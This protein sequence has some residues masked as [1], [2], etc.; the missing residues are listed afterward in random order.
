MWRTRDGCHRSLLVHARFYHFLTFKG[1]KLSEIWPPIQTRTGREI[2]STF[3]TLK[4]KIVC[5][6]T[7]DITIIQPLTVE[8]LI[9]DEVFHYAI[10]KRPSHGRFLNCRSFKR[11]LGY[12]QMPRFQQLFLEHAWPSTCVEAGLRVFH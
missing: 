6:T 8:C 12:L 1:R 5:A 2:S 3:S 9:P 7:G 4:K 11:L 10:E